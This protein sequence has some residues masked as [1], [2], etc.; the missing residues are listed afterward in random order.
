ME[1]EK[2]SVWK[3]K[4]ALVTGATTGIGEAIAYALA[5]LGMTV[6]AA[7][8]R[9]E[10]LDRVVRAICQRGGMAKA[11]CC[12]IGDAEAIPQMFA[13][14]E[15]D[16]GPLDVLINN[17]GVGYQSAIADFSTA[18]LQQALDV[19]VLGTAICI[20]EAI[21]HMQHRPET[22]IIT[23]SSMA[24]HRT[25]PG[26]YGLYSATKHA[27]R[28][29]MEALRIE[30]V[31]IDSPTKIASISPGTVATDFHKLFARSDSDPTAKL[32]FERLTAQD[33]SDAVVYVLGTP[34]HVQVSDIFIRPMGQLG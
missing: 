16:T 2:S 10:E 6:A 31:S 33:I 12:D 18:D 7:G 1:T 9:R 28:A 14:I 11:Y 27:L 4:T 29:I 3:K 26:G 15:Q 34:S 13:D 24:A 23:I 19:N 32:S 5:D 21:K 17:A 22:A 20:R 25:P 30:L 8:R